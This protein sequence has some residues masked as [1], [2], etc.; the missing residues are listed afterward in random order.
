MLNRC[1]GQGA[2]MA[3]AQ[4]L[5]PAT[6]ASVAMASM[7]PAWDENKAAGYTG[8]DLYKRVAADS[9]HPGSSASGEVSRQWIARF[10][11]CLVANSLS[12]PLPSFYVSW[13]LHG[14]LTADCAWHMAHESLSAI[15]INCGGGEAIKAA[16]D[17]YVTFAGEDPATILDP[18][19]GYGYTVEIRDK[20][21]GE[22]TTKYG[23]M[24]VGSLM[25]GVGDEVARGDGIGL[26]GSTGHSTGPH[27]H[28]EVRH[29][30]VTVCPCTY[31]EGG[32]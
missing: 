19:K 16:H 7:K 12:F 11:Q 22:Y 1:G 28:F 25:V 26:C 23:H 10:T 13:P 3:C 8:F 14:T 4:L 29:N 32:C 24:Q 9:G 6:N 18:A 21:F 20:A 30:G 5:D 31:L 27:L 17:G 15:D 2:G